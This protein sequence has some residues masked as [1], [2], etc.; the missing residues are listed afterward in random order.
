[1][2]DSFKPHPDA[3]ARRHAEQGEKDTSTAIEILKIA[4]EATKSQAPT[5]RDLADYAEVLW[6]WTTSDTWPVTK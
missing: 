1:M 4:H 6:K 3:I 2:A 5:A